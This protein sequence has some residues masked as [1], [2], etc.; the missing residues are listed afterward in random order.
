MNPFASAVTITAEVTK[1]CL[2]PIR[3]KE[4]S[5]LRGK[6]EQAEAPVANQRAARLGGGHL[7][8]RRRQSA[9]LA[10]QVKSHLPR[11][12]RPFARSADSLVRELLG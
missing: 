2:F 8:R 4:H 6:P 1:L 11:D 10:R 7:F 5:R 12:G 9:K 3:G